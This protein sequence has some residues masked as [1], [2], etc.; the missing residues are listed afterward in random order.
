MV[1]KLLLGRQLVLQARP[2]P[3]YQIEAT[4][5]M[6]RLTNNMIW[7]QRKSSADTSSTEVVELGR[8]QYVR[9]KQT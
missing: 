6:P 8:D 3:H 1:A 9:P 5:E 7:E 4:F 2:A